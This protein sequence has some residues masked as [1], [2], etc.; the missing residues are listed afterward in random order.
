MDDQNFMALLSK[1][2]YAEEEEDMIHLSNFFTKIVTAVRK[3]RME[4][5]LLKDEEI[6]NSIMSSITST[7]SKHAA[8]IRSLLTTDS[9]KSINSYFSDDER[10]T[11][12][13]S[14]FFKRN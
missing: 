5:K 1:K 4:V 7:A 12:E 2:N 13:L 10:L 9:L 14:C 6:Q 8:K 11:A 3:M